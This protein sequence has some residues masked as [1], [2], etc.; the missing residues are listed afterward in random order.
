MTWQLEDVA[1][2]WQ[3]MWQVLM[4]AFLEKNGGNTFHLLTGRI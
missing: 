2:T 3:L 4:S 1:T